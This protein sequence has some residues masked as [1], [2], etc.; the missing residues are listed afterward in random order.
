M[1]KVILLGFE[2]ESSN[3]GCEAL[4]YSVMS[5]LD[6]MDELKPLEII[7]INIHDSIGEFQ[8]L[9]PNIK[10]TKHRCTRGTNKIKKK[11]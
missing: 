1:M 4:S 8:T 9:Y 6:S 5:L 11:C 10:F 2:F 7:N 3:K